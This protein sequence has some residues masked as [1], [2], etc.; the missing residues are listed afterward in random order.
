VG[1]PAQPGGGRAR[2]RASGRR[3]RLGARKGRIFEFN[4]LDKVL[5]VLNVTG[6]VAGRLPAVGEAGMGYSSLKARGTIEGTRVTAEELALDADRLTIA[7]RGS[8]DYASERIDATI[9]VAPLPTV[10]W[11][12]SEI[13]VLGRVFGTTIVAMPVQVSGTIDAPVVL[14]LGPEAV[15]QRFTELLSNTLSLPAHL[16]RVVPAADD[17]RGGAPKP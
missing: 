17:R 9:L 16:I 15:A 6:F 4:S 14:P 2:A 10:S 12:V 8:A 3:H 5:S 13:P 1:K 11:I 7:A